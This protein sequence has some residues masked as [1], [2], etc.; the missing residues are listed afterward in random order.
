MIPIGKETRKP[1]L[2]LESELTSPGQ[3]PNNT[4]ISP[5]TTTLIDNNI[6]SVHSYYTEATKNTVIAK[7]SNERGHGVIQMKMEM[8]LLTLMNSNNQQ[9]ITN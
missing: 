3:N 6:N 4:A 8:N 7:L 2:A 9:F 1:P 5:M